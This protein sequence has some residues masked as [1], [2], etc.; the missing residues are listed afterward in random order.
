MEAQ[1]KEFGC[2]CKAVS[3]FV[4]QSMLTWKRMSRTLYNVILI[5]RSSNTFSLHILPVHL[6]NIT[7]SMTRLLWSRMRRRVRSWRWMAA[8]ATPLAR[9][10]MN[11]LSALLTPL[12]QEISMLRRLPANQAHLLSPLSM[13]QLSRWAGIPVLYYR[14]EKPTSLM[15]PPFVAVLLISLR[16]V[17]LIMVVVTTTKNDPFSL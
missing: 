4:R 7:M 15:I 13:L 14:I 5:N 1:I 8:L 16:I 17:Q 2:S 12:S 6:T 10:L 3:T 9:S 11:P